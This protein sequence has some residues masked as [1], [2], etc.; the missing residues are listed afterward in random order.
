VFLSH[1]SF[2][3]VLVIMRIE[4]VTLAGGP[5]KVFRS[6][7]APPRKIPK[8]FLR[9]NSKKIRREKIP[10]RDSCALSFFSHS[11]MSARKLANI[12]N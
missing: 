11:E 3:L 7:K 4:R 6:L 1:L 9:K 12:K 8:S 10:K 5:K 2:T